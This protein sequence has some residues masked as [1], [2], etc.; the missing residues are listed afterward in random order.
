[1]IRKTVSLHKRNIYF[2]NAIPSFSSFNPFRPGITQ[3]EDRSKVKISHQ[4]SVNNKVPGH[5]YTV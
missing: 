1:M 3:K 4:H 5:G 2:S